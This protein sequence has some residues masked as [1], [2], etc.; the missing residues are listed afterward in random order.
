MLT[1]EDVLKR[2]RPLVI[3][4]GGGVD[5]TGT[6]IGL[7]ARGIVPD[8]IVFADTGG[9]KPGTYAWLD[10]F[11][12]WLRDNGFP[13]VTRVCY[14][15]KYST[16]RTLEEE[17][18]QKATLP[19]RVFGFGRCAEKWKVRAQAQWLRRWTLA[20]EAKSRGQAVI[21][22]VSYEA[23]EEHRV[24]GK[25][26]AGIELWYP[27]IEWGWTRDDC[28]R[29]IEGA[30][31]P[32][33]PKSACFFCPSSTK[34]EVLWLAEHHPDLFARAVAMEQRAAPN[35]QNVKGLGRHWAW[36]ALVKASEEER[37]RLAE[38][39]VE[40]CTQCADDSDSCRL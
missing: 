12:V 5:S 35:M 39:P 19:S 9:E 32:V 8:A 40:A 29:A 10:T 38:A 33:P 37:R 27:L 17:C 4:Y 7:R 16:Y 15:P 22:A 36:E 24:N 25:A 2:D 1:T 31:L 21:R 20:I 18:E 11:D 23:G 30:G 14:L 6:C 34:K 26:D 28:V 3:A 13:T